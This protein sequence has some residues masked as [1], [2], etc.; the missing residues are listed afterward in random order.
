MQAGVNFVVGEEKE[1]KGEQK[2]KRKTLVM[3]LYVLRSNNCGVIFN[4]TGRKSI[5]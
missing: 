1:K 5:F 4:R 3:L 2:I